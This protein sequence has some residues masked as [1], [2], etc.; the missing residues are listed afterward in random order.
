MAWS[1]TVIALVDSVSWIWS[2]SSVIFSWV[3]WFDTC[4]IFFTCFHT[5]SPGVFT[6][7]SSASQYHSTFLWSLLNISIFLLSALLNTS[8][9]K[10]S[11][12]QQP[13][14]LN[15]PFFSS[16]P[17]LSLSQSRD[18]LCVSLRIPLPRAIWVPPSPDGL[19]PSLPVPMTDVDVQIGPTTEE[20]EEYREKDREKERDREQARECESLLFYHQR[21]SSSS[22]PWV[23]KNAPH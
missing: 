6:H 13:F 21:S 18:P 15:V 4:Y 22:Q 2:N 3:I 8:S 12:S 19:C 11:L 14:H 7:N 16:Q 10:L 1:V 23:S 5:F 17:F 20:E 9:R